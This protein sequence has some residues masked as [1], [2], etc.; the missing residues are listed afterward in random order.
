MNLQGFHT[1]STWQDKKTNVLAASASTFSR[2]W[3]A[4]P[5]LMQFSSAS[6]LHPSIST[7][8]NKDVTFHLLVRPIDGAI[9]LGVLCD[10]TEAQAGMCD[11]LLRLKSCREKHA[12]FVSFLS[13]LQD[14]LHNVWH[15]GTCM[16]Q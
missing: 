13:L 11:E 12:I 2:S 9:E 1:S 3:Q 8:A 5:P 10:V 4:P 15:C 7:L 6:T 14:A 16:Y